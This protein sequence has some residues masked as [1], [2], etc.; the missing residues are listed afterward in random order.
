MVYSGNPFVPRRQGCTNQDGPEGAAAAGLR[1]R[2]QPHASS[3]EKGNAGEW[4]RGWR[5]GTHPGTGR[6]NKAG[7]SEESEAAEDNFLL[8]N[9]KPYSVSTEDK[10]V[11]AAVNG[12]P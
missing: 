6:W 4:R 5:T 12:T 2:A 10:V 3:Q 8:Q 9:V 11:V 7:N 1:L